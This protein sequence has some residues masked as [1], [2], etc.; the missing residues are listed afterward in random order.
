[1]STKLRLHR[2]SIRTIVQENNINIA[3]IP[4]KHY[5]KTIAYKC[6][7]INCH[8][9]VNKTADFKVELIEHNL[10]VCALRETWI[11][12]GDDT[13]VIQL[14]PDGYSFISMPRAGRTGGDIVIVHKSDI[15]LK[16]KT[17]YNYQTMECT[18]FLLNFE[19]V[20][21]NLC[22]IYRPPNTS[23]VAF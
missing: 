7:T 21:I 17:I 10:D 1:M 9:I 15:T 19:N 14:C 16:S 2:S 5:R 8:S 13:M 23:I 11:K 22:V 20:L 6:A 12:E 4:D 3:L 18:D